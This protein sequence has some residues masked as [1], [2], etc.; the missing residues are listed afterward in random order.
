MVEVVAQHLAQGLQLGRVTLRGRRGVRVQVDQLGRVETRVVE[1][2]LYRGRDTA[3]GRLRLRDV[4]AVRGQTLAQH[5][6]VDPGTA[7]GGVLGGLQD[8]DARALAQYEAVTGLVVRAGGLLGV[9]VVLGHRHHVGERGDR[10]RVDR[11]LGAAR[12]DHV[13][14]AGTDHLDGVADGLGAGRA[15]ADRSVHARLG[16]D[17]QADVGRRAVR[18]EHGDG[19]RGDP[20]HALVL[21]DV[22]LVEQGGDTADAG[23]D[24]GAQTLRR[25][26]G[27]LFRL[28]AG[29]GG[30]TGVG[31][32]L[33]GRDDGE[34][35]RTV[36]L[37]GQRPGQD[38]TR[39][40]GGPSGD[41]YRE[42][43]EALAL[44]GLHAGTAGKQTF[45]GRSAVATQRSGCADT[46]D[47]HG[48]IGRA[49][50]NSFSTSQGVLNCHGATARW[51]QTLVRLR[52]PGASGCSQRRRRPS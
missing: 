13:G 42:F 47:D 24:H 5:L 31:P 7:R 16:V 40:D 35:R 39:V 37:A 44:Q 18:H 9:L 12:D 10:Q 14:A 17:L 27:A 38:L 25:D 46:G 36:Q 49:H 2:V 20:A 4:V 41:A 21:Q 26:E 6:A 45:P 51:R 22:V 33:A 28:F 15:G 43:G 48:A 8:D 3:A 29:R 1:Q 30:V 52:R 34:L 23:G 32:R 50:R 11:R 19:V